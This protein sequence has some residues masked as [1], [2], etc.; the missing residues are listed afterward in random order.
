MKPQTKRS[1]F[2]YLLTV[3]AVM[4]GLL[5]PAAAA[6]IQDIRLSRLTWP[7]TGSN[8]HYAYQGTL[9][10]R[11][12]ALNAY[13]NGSPAISAGERSEAA[14]PD[15]LWE[16]LAAFLPLPESADAQ[17]YAFALAP[18]QYSA[19]YRYL[20]I[21]YSAPSFSL[22]V[23]ADADTGLPL[24]IELSCAPET[25]EA[26]MENAGVWDILR[27]YAALLDLGEPTDGDTSI[28]SILHSQSAQLRETSFEAVLTAMPASGSLLLK[29]T[30]SA[31]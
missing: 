4:I 18:K 5:L 6:H 10:N 26:H 11:V 3:A 12:I 31:P 14:A 2:S 20:D 23:T 9:E 8:A 13:L 21:C 30:G 1:A 27:A 16:A 29:L 24:R 25:L 28:S 22:A 19:E 17:A 15:W 7:L